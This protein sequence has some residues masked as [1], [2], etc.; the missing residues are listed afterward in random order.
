[1]PLQPKDHLFWSPKVSNTYQ[2]IT[3]IETITWLELRSFL[4]ICR[5]KTI[6]QRPFAFLY[7][8][9]LRPRQSEDKRAQNDT[10]LER[11]WTLRNGVLDALDRRKRIGNALKT[12]LE[13]WLEEHSKAG[14]AEESDGDTE[15]QDIEMH[16]DNFNAAVEEADTAK[17]LYLQHLQLKPP[18]FW[19]TVKVW[20]APIQKLQ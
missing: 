10:Y 12:R 3:R 11:W 14:D 17:T 2:T 5:F 18:S 16:C 4:F 6:I 13:A 15:R 9:I 1:M 20:S 7:K 8:S 19:V